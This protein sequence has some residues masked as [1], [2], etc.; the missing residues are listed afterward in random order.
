MSFDEYNA[1]KN[2]WTLFERVWSYN[3][4]VRAL[5]RGGGA[6]SY[7]QF[8]SNSERLSYIRGQTAHV[9]IHGFPEDAEGFN[10]IP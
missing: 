3:Y 10:N 9:A 2:D 4:T 8:L 5:R 7:Y 6:Q 1:Y